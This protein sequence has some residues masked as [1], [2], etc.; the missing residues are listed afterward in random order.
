V[1][2]TVADNG[3]FPPAG[4]RVLPLLPET[5][6]PVTTGTSRATGKKID[7]YLAIC[8]FI[9]MA[10]RRDY[11]LEANQTATS[12]SVFMETYNRTLPASFTPASVTALKKFQSLHPSLFKNSEEWSIEK[13]RK[14][15]LEWLPS[16]H[17]AT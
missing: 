4:G 17:D 2:G 15:L 1:R 14:K 8:Y 10:K 9:Y 5:A 11:E 16:N 13:H 7:L 6:V 12:L 3:R